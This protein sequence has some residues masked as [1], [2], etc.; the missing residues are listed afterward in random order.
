MSQLVADGL[1]GFFFFF[2]C[3]VCV[4]GFCDQ[5]QARM[6]VTG[7]GGVIGFSVGL[8]MKNS[9]GAVGYIRITGAGLGLFTAKT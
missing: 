6:V 8:G 9:C 5:R 1:R 4:C 7:L 2:F 3:W